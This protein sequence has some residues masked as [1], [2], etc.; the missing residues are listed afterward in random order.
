MLFACWF[1]Q[2][3]DWKQI[4]QSFCT[5]NFA[6]FTLRH[7]LNDLTYTLSIV[8]TLC[9]IQRFSL[10]YLDFNSISLRNTILQLKGWV[11]NFGVHFCVQLTFNFY[12]PIS[13]NLVTISHYRIL[14]LS[15][16]LNFAW[17]NIVVSFVSPYFS[18][19]FCF[20]FCLSVL[21]VALFSSSPPIWIRRVWLIVAS[22]PGALQL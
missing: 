9:I 12:I 20:V 8:L 10:C 4:L 3:S 7:S 18:I 16:R 2:Q 21:S 11:Q 15:S 22:C 13:S 5:W 19:S 1:R 6:N 14:E 17:T